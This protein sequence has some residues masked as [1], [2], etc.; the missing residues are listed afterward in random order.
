MTTTL[1]ATAAATEVRLVAS[2]DAAGARAIEVWRTMR[3]TTAQVR[4]WPLL[5]A[6]AWAHNDIDIL[7]GADL[8]YEALIFDDQGKLLES[9]PKTGPLRVV[10]GSALIRDALLTTTKMPV[11]LV[12]MEAGDGVTDVRRE[13]LTPV[14]RRAPVAITD[15]RSASSG[16]TSVLTLTEAEHAQ[17]NAMLDRGSVLLFTGPHDFDIQWPL[18]VHFGT[19]ETRRVSGRLDQAR[20]W[21]LEWVEVDPPP[22]VEPVPAR[23]W[24]Q[25]LD[26]GQTWQTLRASAWLDVLYPPAGV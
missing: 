2:T 12:G 14:G 17:M 1:T 4:A 23:T 21:V 22:V 9:S 7:F 20:L 15:V 5:D 11:R 6:G 19:V 16:T 8:E 3:G 13:L 24:Q 18:Y 26:D 10:H 25:L